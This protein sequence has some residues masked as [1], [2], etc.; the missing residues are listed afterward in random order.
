MNEIDINQR[1]EPIEDSIK[2]IYVVL[3]GIAIIL[4]LFL[5]SLN[6]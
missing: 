3:L 2:S 4:L 5:V 6:F 1:I